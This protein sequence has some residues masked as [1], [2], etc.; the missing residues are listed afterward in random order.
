MPRGFR[1]SGAWF[2][3]AFVLLTLLPLSDTLPGG[4]EVTYNHAWRLFQQG[5]LARSQQEA[6]EGYKQF[7]RFSPHWA[8][9][10]QL[11]AA[12]SMLYRGMYD[13]TLNTLASYHD[14]GSRDGA[15]KKRTLEAIALIRQGQVDDARERLAQADALC[16]GQELRTC[17]DVLWARALLAIK[18]G[19]FAEA[20]QH[21]L[22]T[23]A[24]A[25]RYSD[26]WLQASTTLNLGYIAMQLDH[27]DEA[28]DWSRSAY[29][30]AF[31][32]G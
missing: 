20:R 15:V 28:V 14:S 26:R 19:Q 31:A 8:G 5:Y 30:D 21:L 1:A 32:N 2:L 4:A 9:E 12:E 3:A 11:L 25:R 29:Q 7:Q 6:E 18:T 16:S 23:L 24:I 27:Y 10:F 17:G 22:N 13:D